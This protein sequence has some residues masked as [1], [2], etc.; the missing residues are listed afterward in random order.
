MIAVERVSLRA[1]TFALD[2]LSFA[3]PTGAYAVSC[4]LAARDTGAQAECS[5]PLAFVRTCC[6]GN[7]SARASSSGFYRLQRFNQPRNIIRLG[8]PGTCPETFG[9]TGGGVTAQQHER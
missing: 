8:Q 1:G 2:D 9:Q 4:N 3:V 7:C 5:G 6:L